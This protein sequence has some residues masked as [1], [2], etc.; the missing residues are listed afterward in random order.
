MS[1][2]FF[3][4][5]KEQSAVKA[6]IVSKYFFAWAKVI[7]PWAKKGGGRIAYIDLF[8]GPGRYDDGTVSTPLLVLEKAIQDDDLRQMLMAIFNDADAAHCHALEQAIRSLPGIESL[9]HKPQVHNQDVGIEIISMF[10]KMKLVPTLFFIDPWGYKGLSLRLINSVLRNWGCDCIF[11]FNYNRISMG[12]PNEAVEDHMNALFGSDRADALRPTLRDL[13]P[14]DRELAI[15]AALCDALREM[16]GEYVLPFRF[17]H[18]RV[19]RTSHHLVFV[20]KHPLGYKIMKGIMAAESTTADQGVPS[21]EYNPALG[22]QGLLF[23]LSRPL[24][25]LREMVLQRFAGQILNFDGIFEQHHVNTPFIESNYR[26]VLGELENDGIIQVDRPSRAR[27]TYKGK[28]AYGKGTMITFP[29]ITIG[30]ED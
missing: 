7:I 13:S 20:S 8:A 29:D 21:F 26:D 4:E 27:K 24:D 16:G 14:T 15:V 3:N 28:P 2:R 5:A 9:T 11:F 18:P 25:D 12:L 23:D 10:E 19:G 6:A 1:S 22:K 17:H 30:P